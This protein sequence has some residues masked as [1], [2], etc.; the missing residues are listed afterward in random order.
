MVP[1]WIQSD[2]RRKVA[3]ASQPVAF[4]DDEPLF[5]TD[6]QSGE[7]NPF[8]HGNRTLREL[9][10]T[11]GTDPAFETYLKAWSS[12][13]EAARKELALELL[14]ESTISWGLVNTTITAHLDHSERLIG[15]ELPG[16]LIAELE[17]LLAAD[18]PKAALRRA[19]QGAVS[20]RLMAAKDATR[21]VVDEIFEALRQHRGPRSERAATTEL[22]SMTIEE[23]HERF[24]TGSMILAHMRAVNI[25]LDGQRKEVE[26]NLT[27][28]DLVLC[29]DAHLLLI[30]EIERLNQNLLN[31]ASTNLADLA[32][33]LFVTGSYP[34]AEARV[35]KQFMEH[36]NRARTACDRN[37]KRLRRR[38]G[39]TTQHDNDRRELSPNRSASA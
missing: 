34:E 15:V 10:E 21:A 39:N 36:I 31:D 25:V 32:Y 5:P 18:A 4:D 26:I 11:Y 20:V 23:L 8:A 12:L 1:F 29:D 9:S 22:R 24:A 6:A 7:P 16:A 27:R 13:Q 35:R 19:V 38:N 37:L 2:K 33:A 17:P 3:A 14:R 30:S 28:R